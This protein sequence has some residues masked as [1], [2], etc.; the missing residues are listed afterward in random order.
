VWA[1]LAGGDAALVRRCLHAAPAVERWLVRRVRTLRQTA[2]AAD[3][4]AASLVR[5]PRA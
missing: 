1:R 3:P 4:H 2:A 5:V